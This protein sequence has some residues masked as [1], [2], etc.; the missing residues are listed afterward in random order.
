MKTFSNKVSFE[1]VNSIVQ[2]PFNAKD[3]FVTYEILVRIRRN[4]NPSVVA[5]KSLLFI[6]HCL[7]PFEIFDRLRDNGGFNVTCNCSVKTVPRIRFDNGVLEL[8][9]H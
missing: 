5:K 1:S 8:S 9:C 7:E 2:M 3:P 6:M 4:K